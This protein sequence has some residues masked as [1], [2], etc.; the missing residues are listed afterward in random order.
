MKSRLVK[1]VVLAVAVAVLFSGCTLVDLFSAETLLRPPR[2]TGENAALQSAFEGSVGTDIGLFTPLSGEFRSSYILF[3][4]DLDGEDEAIVFYSSNTDKNVVHMHLLT[5]QKD[6]WVSIA[7]IIGSGTGVYKVDFFNIDKSSELEI[8][9]MWSADDSKRDKTLSIY[10]IQSLDSGFGDNITSLAT[11]LVSDYINVDLDNDSADEL[12]YMY[13]SVSDD[14]YYS[15]ARLMDY[16]ISQKSLV[17]LSEVSFDFQIYS[18]LNIS[19]EKNEDEY[20]FYLDCLLPNNSYATELIFYGFETAS[21]TVPQFDSKSLAYY[22]HRSIDISCE[23]FDGDGYIDVPIHKDTQSVNIVGLPTEEKAGLEC[24][25]WCSVGDGEL[26]VIGNYI[27]NLI[28]GYK[29]NTDN[30]IEEYCFFYEYQKKVL[31]VRT[32][33]SYSD[34]NIVFSVE[35]KTVTENSIIA[36]SQV[37]ETKIVVSITELGNQLGFNDES[38]KVDLIIN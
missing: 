31:Q 6:N 33:D 27:V 12:L 2:L 25:T 37:T 29:M 17:P 28:D 20:R 36:Q 23:D 15:G 1:T 10:K 13:F 30:L 22:S 26:D 7:D 35:T 9:V 24:I 19:S 32:D 11:I 38:V 4:A 21:L 8:A 5:R 14:V 16:D 18:Y 34:E 3:D